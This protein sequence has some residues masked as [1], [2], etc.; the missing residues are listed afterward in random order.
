[1]LDTA[2]RCIY[3]TQAH[4]ALNVPRASI[5]IRLEFGQMFAVIKTGGKQYKVAANDTL[6]IEKL[7]GE[8]GE[9]IVFDSVLM[10][11]EGESVSVG[12]PFVEGAS[13][14]AEV[15]EQTRGEKIIVFKKKRRQNYRRKKGHRQELTAVKITEILTG[16]KKPAKAKAAAKPK[17][18][19]AED[20]PAKAA[21]AAPKAELKAKPAEKEAPV[22]LFTAPEGPADDLKKISG[23]GKVLEKKLNDL[24]ITRYD[25]IA[26]FSADEIAKVDEVLNFKGRIEREDWTSQAKALAEGENPETE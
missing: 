11:S 13:V 4:A 21:D 26:A 18:A 17:P 5:F 7:A 9:Q 16:G 22:A 1:M 19:K 15:V 14:A 12:A 25:Q 2:V 24:G 8:P 23:V 10:V 20:K 6:K 3:L